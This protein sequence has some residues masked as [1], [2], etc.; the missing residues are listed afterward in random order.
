MRDAMS[1]EAVEILGSSPGEAGSL[2]PLASDPIGGRYLLPVLSD[3]QQRKNREEAAKHVA[4]DALM[5]ELH[6][7]T[8]EFEIAWPLI[9][10]NLHRTPA[11]KKS[12]SVMAVL[13][14][15]L[16]HD[17]PF[18]KDCIEAEVDFTGEGTEDL[19][20]HGTVCALIAH[21]I[22]LQPRLLN[23]KVVDA[24]GRGTPE[25]LSKGIQWLARYAQDHPQLTFIANISL[26]VYSRK[27][28]GLLDCQG[29]CKVCQAVIEAA[30]QQPQNIF[31]TIAAGNKAGV[32]TC[33]AKVGL[34]EHYSSLPI[35]AVTSEAIL[36]HKAARGNIIAPGK[37]NFMFIDT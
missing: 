11:T 32:P 9:W 13:D 6:L 16:M 26:G 24:Q 34:I 4:R 25:N 15:G 22:I 7:N 35:L 2:L 5:A 23:I 28:G 12:D 37:Y 27:F 30:N 8:T 36:E 17:H 21:P 29:D 18:I 20:G 10:A 33:P 14:S 19:N 31:F 1:Q 3:E